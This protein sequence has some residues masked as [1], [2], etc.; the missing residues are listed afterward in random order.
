MTAELLNPTGIDFVDQLGPRNDYPDV[1]KF[2]TVEFLCKEFVRL[3]FD[4]QVLDSFFAKKTKLLR[5]TKGDRTC[6]AVETET[7]F[8]SRLAIRLLIRKDLAREIFAKAGLTVA[9]GYVFRKKQKRKALKRL[10]QMGVAVI[11]PVDGHQGK[12]ITVGVTAEGFDEAWAKATAST[13]RG[14]LL[15][16]Q[17][18]GIEARYLVVDGTC[19]AV[20]RR[21][22]PAVYGDGCRTVREL[23]AQRNE[24]RKLNPNLG[25]RPVLIDAHREG[26]IRAQGFDLDSVPPAGKQVI[27]DLKAGISTGADSQ[28]LTSHVHPSMK[29]VAETVAHLI[30]GLDVVGVDIISDD[31][32]APADKSNYVIIEAN[33]R[34]G[35]G[36]HMFP[37]YGQ[38][39]NVCKFI[40]ESCAR[41]MGFDIQPEHTQPA[42]TVRA[43]PERG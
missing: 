3:G 27:I 24:R 12:G 40:A 1:G 36:S 34:P 21:I 7:S 41:K 18:H 15:E 20:L 9:E 17:V 13:R 19:V 10:K 22:P 31:H 25:H 42:G 28:D 43:H 39:V 8:T 37:A 29:K 35:I 14:V 2:S 16:R 11:K 30:P 6:L 4:G 23:V 38:S 5:V 32:S 33:T 26:M